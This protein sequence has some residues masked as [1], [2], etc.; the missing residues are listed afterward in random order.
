M[1]WGNLERGIG[2][3]EVSLGLLLLGNASWYGSLL[4]DVFPVLGDVAGV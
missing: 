2:G 4:C 1:G 3:Q